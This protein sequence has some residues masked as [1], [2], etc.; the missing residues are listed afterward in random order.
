MYNNQ[1]KVHF[2]NCSTLHVFSR[3]KE[4]FQDYTVQ[5]PNGLEYKNTF[6]E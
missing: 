2:C 1:Y 3:A 6:V 4:M 5:T